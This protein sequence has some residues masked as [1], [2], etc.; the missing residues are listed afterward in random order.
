[1]TERL[2]TTLAAAFSGSGQFERA[3]EL[4]QG[5]LEYLEPRLGPIHPTVLAITNNFGVCLIE[6]RRGGEAIVLLSGALGKVDGGRFASMEP[7]VRRNLGHAH[8][9]AGDRDAA[10]R[11]L[12]RAYEQSISQNLPDNARRTAGLLAIMLEEFHDPTASKWRS[13]AEPASVGSE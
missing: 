2:R 13:L 10:E 3:I 8:F 6:A 5:A 7:V 9:A 11:E 12:R 1:L 4:Y